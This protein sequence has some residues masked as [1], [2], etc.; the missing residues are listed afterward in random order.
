[1][2]FTWSPVYS[3]LASRSPLRIESQS[4]SHLNTRVTLVLDCGGTAIAVRVTTKLYARW[5]RLSYEGTS[6]PARLR[7][8]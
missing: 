4:S 8:S 7:I 6:H 5:C 3:G 2:A 1:M